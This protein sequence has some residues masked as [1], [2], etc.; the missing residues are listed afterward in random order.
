MGRWKNASAW[1]VA[2]TVIAVATCAGSAGAATEGGVEVDTVSRFVWRG[3]AQ[4]RGAAVQP[5][6]W[7]ATHDV[8]A[9]VWSSVALVDDGT[10]RRATAYV[11]S[12]VWAHDFDAWTFS[13]GVYVEAGV[14]ANVPTT[15]EAAFDVSFGGD[16]ARVAS[17]NRIDFGGER[18]AYFGDL[19]LSFE[20]DA[21]GGTLRTRGAIAWGTTAF[22]RA[23]FAVDRDA[24]DF[25][26]FEIAW[27]WPMA[28]AFYLEPHAQLTTI[29]PPVRAHVDTPT[30]FVA[31]IGVGFEP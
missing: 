4:G 10:G 1:R 8:T 31:G 15:S 19:A 20:D 29:L 16:H 3:R 21:L 11:P 23:W 30:F 18:G 13:T 2:S 24:I 27:R 7:M 9:S 14:A 28:S 5:S 25:A 26:S 6:L 17:E 22:N 12:L